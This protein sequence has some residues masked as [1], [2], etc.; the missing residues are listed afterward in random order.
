MAAAHVLVSPFPLQGHINCMLHFATALVG[1]GVQVT[2]LH[3]EHNLRRLGGRASTSAPAGSSPRIRFLSIPDGLPDDRRR[4]VADIFE[5][6]KSLAAEAIG[7]YRALLAPSPTT[8]SPAADVSLDPTGGF[9]PLTCLV[10]D[11]LLPW[12]LDAAEE[13]GV[14]AIA[15][16]TVSA[17]SFLAYLSVP[18]LFELGELPFPA[19]GA[20]LDEP[21]RG[22]PGMES[23]LRR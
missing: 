9:P 10:A 11:G 7:P 23:L 21:V 4:S 20:G 13:L 6:Y 18:K 2:F 14:P 1:A 3:T 12:A 15:F 5:L 19:G 17:C 22:V 8:G 16:R